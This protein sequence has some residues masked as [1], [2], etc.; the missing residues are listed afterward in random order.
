M[1][2]QLAK[3]TAIAAAFLGSVQAVAL[4]QATSEASSSSSVSSLSFADVGSS[5]PASWRGKQY[6]CKCYIG[7]NC[8]PSANKWRSLNHTVDGSL[9][10]NIPPGASCY[11]T[12][13]GP[14][15]TVNTYD[16]AG[17]AEATAQWENETWQ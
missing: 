4:P 11:N 13:N 9:I 6:A 12:F 15:G 7:H 8:W 16:E 10:V 1:S 3:I 14:L 17:C 2:R 5:V